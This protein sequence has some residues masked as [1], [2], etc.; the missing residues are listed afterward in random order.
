[1]S[2]EEKCL[3]IPAGVD[4]MSSY[5][6]LRDDLKSLSDIIQLAKENQKWLFI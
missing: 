5:F 1:M 2:R 4:P 6:S 3:T